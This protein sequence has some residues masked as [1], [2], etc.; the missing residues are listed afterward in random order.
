MKSDFARETTPWWDGI[1]EATNGH[2]IKGSGQSPTDPRQTHTTDT[3][4]H[5]PPRTSRSWLMVF[6]RRDHKF[7]I[8]KKKHQ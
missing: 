3:A 8:L 2:G 6:Y 1:K 4:V 5:S 7:Q